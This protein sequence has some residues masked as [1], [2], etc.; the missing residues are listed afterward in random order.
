MM[1][2]EWGRWLGQPPHTLPGQKNALPQRTPRNPWDCNHNSALGW[3]WDKA[4]VKSKCQGYLRICMGS[5]LGSGLGSKWGVKEGNRQKGTNFE[6]LWPRGNAAA[7]LCIT[8]GIAKYLQ[9][10]TLQQFIW[11][12]VFI[13]QHNT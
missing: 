8:L 13:L 5:G 6:H 10:Y 2:D 1:K 3:R 9:V 11:V 4:L 12:N 7:S